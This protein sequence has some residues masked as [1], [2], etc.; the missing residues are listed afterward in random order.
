MEGAIS[1]KQVEESA[2]EIRRLAI[3]MSEPNLGD[4]TVFSD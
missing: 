1:Y 4:S 2:N 3:S